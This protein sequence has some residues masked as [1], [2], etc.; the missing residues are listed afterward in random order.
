MFVE[1]DAMH[2]HNPK[3]Y[4]DLVRSLRDRTFG[5]K[6]FLRPPQKWKDHFEGLIGPKVQQ[7]TT[8]EELVLFIEQNCDQGK[9][10]L[11]KPFTRSEVLATSYSVIVNDP[12]N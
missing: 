4:M 1:L 2:K 10:C 9:S 12:L 8:D 11:D 5:K 7:C 6:K 3:G